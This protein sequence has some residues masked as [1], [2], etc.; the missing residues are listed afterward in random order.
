MQPPLILGSDHGGY[1]LKQALGPWLISHGYTVTDLGPSRLDLDDDYPL[2]TEKVAQEVRATGGRGILL[3]RSGQGVAMVA[4]KLPKIRAATAWNTA[5]A[6]AARED[7]DVNILCLPSD[8]VDQKLAKAI[9]L[10]W[11]DARLKQEEP[12]Q[13]RLHEIDLLENKYFCQ[14][15]H[16]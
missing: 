9:V 1:E 10:A 13:R 16:T 6:R 2:I 5:V 7:D 15:E 4:N 14:D 8:Y 12:Y 3:C 11:L